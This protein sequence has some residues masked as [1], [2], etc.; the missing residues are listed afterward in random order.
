ML[1][2][3]VESTKYSCQ[4]RKSNVTYCIYNNVSSLGDTHYYSDVTYSTSTK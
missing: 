1:I 2:D 3:M 4:V